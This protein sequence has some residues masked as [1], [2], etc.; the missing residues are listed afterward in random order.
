M[1][2]QSQNIH[3]Y[4]FFVSKITKNIICRFFFK[5]PP[6]FYFYI[7]LIILVRAIATTLMSLNLF[8]FSVLRRPLQKKK[9]STQ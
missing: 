8:G 4:I 9:L 6:F 3:F 2:E 5:H 1:L 7:K